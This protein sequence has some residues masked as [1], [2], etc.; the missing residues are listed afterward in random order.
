MSI[1]NKFAFFFT[2]RLD[3]VMDSANTSRGSMP[4]LK[5]TILREYKNGDGKL[6]QKTGLLEIRI[7]C[8]SAA[9]YLPVEYSVS[10]LVL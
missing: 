4:D 3:D 10:E 2:N 6:K 9:I 7:T 8:Q 1:W 5:K